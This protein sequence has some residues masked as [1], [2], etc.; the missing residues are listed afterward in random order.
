MISDTDD[1]SDDVGDGDK[2]NDDVML[3]ADYS[4]YSWC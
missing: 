2:N 3:C 1:G 4:G